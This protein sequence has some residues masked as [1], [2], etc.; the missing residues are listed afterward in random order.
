MNK[1]ICSGRLTRDAWANGE[2]T[3]AVKFTVAAKYGYDAKAEKERVEFVQCV[4]FT[5]PNDKLGIFLISQG[6]GVFVEFEGRVATSQFEKDG[7]TRYS[8]QVIV[9]KRTFNIVT[10]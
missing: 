5:K 6:K 8:T 2:N 7:E 1:V 4:L 10:K 3:K 9:D